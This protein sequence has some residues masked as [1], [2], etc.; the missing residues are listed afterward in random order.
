MDPSRRKESDVVRVAEMVHQLVDELNGWRR[1]SGSAVSYT[2]LDVYKRQD[3]ISATTT[4]KGLTIQA[5]YDAH[6]YPKGVKIT[7]TQFEAI[8]ITPHD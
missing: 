1:A 4:Q 6:V 5:A 7:D 2:H 8:P 3:L